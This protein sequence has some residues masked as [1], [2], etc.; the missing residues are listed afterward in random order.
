MKVQGGRVL[1]KNNW[2]RDRDDLWIPRADE[3]RIVKHPP[4]DGFRHLVT[5]PQLRAFL[6]RLPMW[7]EVARGLRGVVL[8]AGDDNLMGW[9]DNGVIGVCAWERELWWPGGVPEFVAEHRHLLDALGVERER[10]GEHCE[11]RWTEAQA[12]AFQ[13]LHIL[14]HELGH[15]RDRMT[16]RSKRQAARGEP[17]AERYANAVFEQLWPGYAAV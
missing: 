14:P 5:V 9:H 6:Q 16:T 3:V 8:D 17:F 2:R 7:D 11:M 10:R 1:R 13:L 12:R 4:G 15:H